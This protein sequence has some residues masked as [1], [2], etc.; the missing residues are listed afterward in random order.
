[1]LSR[2]RPPFGRAHVAAFAVCI[3]SCYHPIV[4][5]LT[6]SGT[7]LVCAWLI[8]SRK[9]K[10]RSRAT[11]QCVV[12]TPPFPLSR[13][14]ILC[15]GSPCRESPSLQMYHITGFF[16]ALQTGCFSSSCCFLLLYTI[17]GKNQHSAPKP[18]YLLTLAPAPPMMPST[19]STVAMEVSPGVVI[20]SAP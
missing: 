5:Q 7:S 18:D 1:M 4:S 14:H 10:R 17:S 19:S 11:P 13:S 20:A 15:I 9:K 16:N 2:M 8:A 6:S 3:Q 12:K